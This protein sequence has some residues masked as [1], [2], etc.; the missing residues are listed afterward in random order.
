MSAQSWDVVVRRIFAP[1]VRPSVVL[2][3]ILRP[4]RVVAA[5]DIAAAAVSVSASAGSAGCLQ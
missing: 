5:A 3:P 2:R 1:V 4:I